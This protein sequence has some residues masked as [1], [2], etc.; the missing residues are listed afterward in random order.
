M[1]KIIQ[2]IITQR[3]WE[4]EQGEGRRRKRKRKEGRKGRMT[5]EMMRDEEED[6]IEREI[7]RYGIAW[8]EQMG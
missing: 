3:E 4:R 8:M 2:R 6:L 5:Y 7:D 1:N